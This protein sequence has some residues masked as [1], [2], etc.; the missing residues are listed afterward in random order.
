MPPPLC[1]SGGE[2]FLLL[3]PGSLQG[4]RSP[5]ALRTRVA[6]TTWS[7]RPHHHLPSAS[8]LGSRMPHAS[9]ARCPF[10]RAQRVEADKAL[11]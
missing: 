7:G 1:R 5:S 3:L 6:T 11:L 10:H 4:R 8:P 2:E 9:I